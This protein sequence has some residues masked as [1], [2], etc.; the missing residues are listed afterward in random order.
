MVFDDEDILGFSQKIILL[1]N[2]PPPPLEK[3]SVDAYA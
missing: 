2:S 1:K 3:I